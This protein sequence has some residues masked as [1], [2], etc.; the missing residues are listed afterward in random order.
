MSYLKILKQFYIQL[1]KDENFRQDS[2]L[3]EQFEDVFRRLGTY[4]ELITGREMEDNQAANIIEDYI[5]GTRRSSLY[6][7]DSDNIKE[8]SLD[9][10]LD[11][12]EL[13]AHLGVGHGEISYNV[14]FA[15]VAKIGARSLSKRH[16]FNRR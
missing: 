15:T 4:H 12:G 3:I 9:Y 7:K 6:G 2:K 8:F 1:G 5:T 13:T 11:K 14:S 16:S 10:D